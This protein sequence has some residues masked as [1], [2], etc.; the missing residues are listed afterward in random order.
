[1]GCVLGNYFH[2]VGWYVEFRV[3]VRAL[4][5]RSPVSDHGWYYNYLL[6]RN[7]AM[8]ADRDQPT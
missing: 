5:E 2:Q 6:M 8:Y 3:N 1:M 4:I 7:Y